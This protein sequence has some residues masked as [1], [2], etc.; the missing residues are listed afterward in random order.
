MTH[1]IVISVKD[2]NKKFKIKSGKEEI[3]I[4]DAL[5]DIN[6]SIE[7]TDFAIIYGP[8][9]C[10]KS[11]LLNTLIGLEEPD[12]GVVSVRGKN[13]YGYSENER[14]KIRNTKYGI[15]YQQ[16]LWIKALSL[17]QNVSMPLLIQGE[18]QAEAEK[19]AKSLLEEFGLG[20]RL[21]NKPVEVSGGQ[22]QK[23]AAARALI[24]NPWIVVADEPTGNLDTHSSDEMMSLFQRLNKDKKRTIIMVTHNLVYLPMAT[25]KIAMIDGKITSE[26]KEVAK[27][28]VDE[29]REAM[30]ASVPR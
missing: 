16:P 1:D 28:I 12:S 27:Q 22:Q 6:L 24:H 7:A 11:T 21:N 20:N 23:A 30:R 13:L 9:G 25:R 19:R 10:G 26:E 5:K 14:A 29:Y 15:I 18:Y 2:V 3:I 8:S 4:S 17:L